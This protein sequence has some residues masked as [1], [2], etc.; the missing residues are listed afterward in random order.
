LQSNLNVT[1][2]HG[3]LAILGYNLNTFIPDD[4]GNEKPLRVWNS[5]EVHRLVDGQWRIVH[6]NYGLTK[7]LDSTPLF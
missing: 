5:T 3:E 7:H 1:A 4:S 6:S 2:W